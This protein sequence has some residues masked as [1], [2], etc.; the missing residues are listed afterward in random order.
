MR[1]VRSK[2]RSIRWFRLESLDKFSSIRI[3]ATNEDSE[4]VSFKEQQLTFHFSL[5]TVYYS[6]LDSL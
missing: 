6:A 3:N 4:A 1:T 2:N 5:E